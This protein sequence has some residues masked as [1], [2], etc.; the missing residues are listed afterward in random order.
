[1][2]AGL[3]GL[4]A[5]PVQRPKGHRGKLPEPVVSL[6]PATDYDDW[7]KRS[8]AERLVVIIATWATIPAVY[9]YWPEEAG[10]PVAL[11]EPEDPYAVGIRG[12]VFE[13]LAALPRARASAPTACRT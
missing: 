12:A 10:T 3:L 2:Q 9:T 6:L 13:A 4:H 1:M 8:P 5:E 11:T 7:L